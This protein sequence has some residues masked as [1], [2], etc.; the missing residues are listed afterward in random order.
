MCDDAINSTFDK[1]EQLVV[2]KCCVTGNFLSFFY[3]KIRCLYKKASDQKRHEK[4]EYLVYMILVITS[5]TEETALIN[6]SKK[7]VIKLLYN[8]ANN[9]Y[10]YTKYGHFIEF[11][12]VTFISS[13]LCDIYFW[14][15]R[16][17]S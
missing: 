1:N 13:K 4:K 3:L 2:P 8:R 14:S 10:S 9:K 15:S 16:V 7:P 11:I 5:V 6:Q 17:A 12:R